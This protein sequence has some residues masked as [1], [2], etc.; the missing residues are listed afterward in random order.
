MWNGTKVGRR[1]FLGAAAAAAAQPA[2]ERP[3][4][5]YIM[6]DQQHAGMM[7]CAGNPWLRTPAMDS[8]AASG[9]RFELAYSSN[10]VC[11]PARTSMMTG[12][13]PSRFDM[14]SNGPAKVP[15]ETLA[16]SLGQVFRRANYRTVFGGKT[17]WPEPMN[18]QTV[19]FEYITRDERD[20]LA[21]ACAAFLREKQERP[22]LLVASFINPH[23]ICY[24]AI[25]AYTKAN[26][27]PAMYPQSRVERQCVAEASRRPAGASEE[28]FIRKLCPPLPANHAPTAD[29]P[30]ALG[31][32]G[33]FRGWARKNWKEEDWRLH[34]WAY[35]R[36]T[37]RVDAEIGRVLA[38][39]RETGLDRNTLVLFSSDHGDMDSAHGFEHKSLPFEESA[40]VPFI[41]SWPGRTPAGRVDR[42]HLVSSCVDLMPTL[43]DYAGIRPPEGL[44][45]RSVRRI[46][47]T[48]SAPAW[49]ED[50]AIECSDS[51]CLRTKR[52][53]YSVF[54]GPGSQ[55]LL[56]DMEKDPGETVNLAGHKKYGAVLADHRRRLRERI[57]ELGDAWGGELTS[58]L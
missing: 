16:N 38:A 12:H 14:R 33:G 37:E 57:R 47:E 25:D 46:V 55:E 52:Y 15:K 35:C 58:R 27:L 7:S 44:P 18:P 45:G 23:D 17:H 31:R 39:L 24:M 50:V 11:M 6:T 26:Q 51:R 49:R 22:F 43:C 34:R 36:L 5:L 8:L 20:G 53:K 29:E 21:G 30:A 10:P 41:L 9:V 48:G 1:G 4:I 19:G 13:Y 2:A 3:N 54:A 32:Y 42:K 28:E 56:V 40:R